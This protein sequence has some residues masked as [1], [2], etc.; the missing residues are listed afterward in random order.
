M[1]SSYPSA[2]ER[3]DTCAPFQ[4]RKNIWE[5]TSTKG[6]QHPPL[7]DVFTTNPEIVYGQIAWAP[8][9]GLRNP[10]AP[11]MTYDAFNSGCLRLDDCVDNSGWTCSE[12]HP[13]VASQNASNITK[14]YNALNAPLDPRGL[15]FRPPVYMMG[16]KAPGAP[17]K[18]G[19]QVF[20]SQPDPDTTGINSVVGWEKLAHPTGS[21]DRYVW[22]NDKERSQQPQGSIRC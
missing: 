8:Q 15:E 19:S 21:G 5:K 6:A 12:K 20:G 13:S 11:L 16:V 7:P 9:R 3:Q 4:G 2:Y 10:Q 18:N 22:Q 1:S 17:A 14:I